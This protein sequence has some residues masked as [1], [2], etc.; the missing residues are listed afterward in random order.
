LFFENLWGNNFWKFET[1]IRIN[2][3]LIDNYRLI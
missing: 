3:P 1:K 2:R